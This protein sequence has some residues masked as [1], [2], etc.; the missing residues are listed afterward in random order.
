MKKTITQL[1][2]TVL[3]MLVAGPAHALGYFKDG[4]I[5]YKT[6][7]DEEMTCTVYLCNV[8]ALSVDIP[9]FAKYDLYKNYK[10][11][12]IMSGA[13]SECEVLRT[14]SIPP[15]ITEIGPY[16]FSGCKN[17]TYLT[18]EK[19]TTELSID[20]KSGL[21]HIETLILKRP[22][23]N[24]YFQGSKTLKTL[25]IG[26]KM[27][28]IGE[29]QFQNCSALTSL[30]I[31]DAVT[32]IGANAFSGFSKLTEVTIPS[33]VT[34]IGEGAFDG[35]DALTKV[36]SKA[37][38]PPTANDNTFSTTTYSTATLTVPDGTAELYEAATCWMRFYGKEP[39]PTDPTDPTDP[40]SIRKTVSD[41]QETPVIYD[42]HG[43]KLSTPSPGINIINGKKVLVK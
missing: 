3:M 28:N 31:G 20:S 38:V 36:T 30:T 41:N 23:S 12:S 40:T 14:V 35:C 1:V 37:T 34:E 10:V 13:F 2:L 27:T 8:D 39:E 11:V 43:R 18:I 42:L 21:S 25:K 24:S 17:L 29:G 19:G 22:L 33:S 9:T 15:T 32:T 5:M 7:S 26:P 4:V 16:A 6:L